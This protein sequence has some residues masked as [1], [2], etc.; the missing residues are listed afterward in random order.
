MV[1]YERSSFTIAQAVFPKNATQ[2]IISVLPLPE[3]KPPAPFPRKSQL[4]GIIIGCIGLLL[5]IVGALLGLK[6]YRK[7]RN[8][9]A[10]LPQE[11]SDTKDPVTPMDQDMIHEAHG[12]EHAYEMDNGI[13]LEMDGKGITAEI[14]GIEPIAEME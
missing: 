6:W 14:Q 13:T 12:Q 3:A 5:M 9:E 7:R 1:D 8:R 10:A 2:Q 4:I 11:Y